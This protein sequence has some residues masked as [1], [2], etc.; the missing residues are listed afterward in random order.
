MFFANSSSRRG[1]C[2]SRLLYLLGILSGV[3]GSLTFIIFSLIPSMREFASLFT[4]AV[5]TL[6]ELILIIP[7]HLLGG[8]ENAE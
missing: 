1:R 3:I 5:L 6:S 4:A 7:T 2:N 8:V